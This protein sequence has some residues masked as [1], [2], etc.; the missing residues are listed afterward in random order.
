MSAQF[1]GTSISVTLNESDARVY[2]AF[3]IDDQPVKRFSVSAG[4]NVYSL[5]TGLSNGT[6]KVLL[7]R[8]SEGNQ[9]GPSQFLGFSFGGTGQLMQ[10]PEYPNKYRLEFVGDSFTAGFGNIGVLPCGFSTET[11]SAF[12]SYAQQTALQLGEAPATNISISGIG[13]YRNYGNAVPVASNPSMPF[14]YPRNLT[15][16]ANSPGAPSIVPAMQPTVV[17]VYLG[18]N[19]FWNGPPNQTDFVSAYVEL[20]K[21]IRARYPSA[22]LIAATHTGSNQQG[23]IQAAYNQILNSGETKIRY[24]DFVIRDWNGCSGHP[25]KAADLEIANYLA[26][27]IRNLGL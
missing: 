17:V 15:G 18:T 10:P 16:E 9:A 25:T 8:E 13:I 21:T 12:W 26:Q 7:M 14:Y 27:F 24:A 23:Y 6:H 11:Q 19:D 3:V 2:Y 1:T 22:M 4:T 20:F 5:A